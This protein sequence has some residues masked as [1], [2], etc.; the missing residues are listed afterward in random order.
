[1][2]EGSPLLFRSFA[3]LLLGLPLA[4]AGAQKSLSSDIWFLRDSLAN[5]VG[6]L[7]REAGVRL[8]QL[9]LPADLKGDG[10]R[11]LQGLLVEYMHIT[12]GG[13]G[14]CLG[15]TARRSIP[16]QHVRPQTCNRLEGAALLLPMQV[17]I[18]SA[19]CALL[20]ICRDCVHLALI[21]SFPLHVTMFAGTCPSL[22]IGDAHRQ[23]GSQRLPAAGQVQ[24]CCGES[25]S[26]NLLPA[27]HLQIMTTHQAWF[28]MH[29][30]GGSHCV[31]CSV[32][33]SA[34]HRLPGAAPR[35]GGPHFYRHKQKLDGG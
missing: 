9:E 11:T 7:L 32:E 5:P 34:C 4:T 21:A 28:C 12:V 3:T 14:G 8:S 29:C 16:A 30:G 27:H 22:G 10:G 20:I 1:M 18:P 33:L 6:A 35:R 23:A 24:H 31:S 15:P 19:A 17:A 13:A 26:P 2:A 25:T